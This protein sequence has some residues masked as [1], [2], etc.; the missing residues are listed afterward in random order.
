MSRY[1]E[2]VS[3]VV[4]VV[5]TDQN[6]PSILSMCS[7][8]TARTDGVVS[9]IPFDQT[10]VSYENQSDYVGWYWEES[11]GRVWQFVSC[12]YDNVV[13]RYYWKMKS[14]YAVPGEGITDGRLVNLWSG[15]LNGK[16]WLLGVCG[17]FLRRYDFDDMFSRKIAEL[18]PADGVDPFLF[19]FDGKVFVL[20][21][22]DFY[23]WDGTFDDITGNANFEEINTNN[24]Y[25]PLVSVSIPPGQGQSGTLLEP[26]NTLTT[27]QRCWI[28][29]DGVGNTFQLPCLDQNPLHTRITNRITGELVSTTQYTE[30]QG[31]VIKFNT[32]PEEGINT[33]E[34][35]FSPKGSS[36]IGIPI[37]KVTMAELYNGVNDSR[38]FYYGDSTNRIYYSDV[39]YNG[40]PRA[41]YVPATN[42][43]DIGESNTPVTCLVRNYSRLLAYKTDS[44][45]SIQY[46]TVTM[47][48]GT[49]SATFY[50]TPVN[51]V[52]GNEAKGQVRIVENTPVS[53]CQK[54]LYEWNNPNG[55]NS[56]VSVDERQAK[57]ISDNV[58]YTIKN[59]D[60]SKCYCFNDQVH[61]EY[62]IC[63]DKKAIVWNYAVDAWYYYT[64]FDVTSMVIWDGEL[65][66]GDSLGRLNHISNDYRTDN[67]V[68]FKCYWESGAE[69]FSKEFMRKY[70]SAL[71]IVVKPELRSEI[72]VTVET[73]RKSNNAIKSVTSSLFTFANADFRKWSFNTNRKPKTNRLKIKAKKFSYYKLILSVEGT[74][75]TA[76]VIA[77]DM[78]VRY[79]GYAK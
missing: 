9:V 57:R 41:D 46:G 1:E 75:T 32:V 73:D 34:I 42:F 48:D 33:Y 66:A 78:K 71:W 40:T 11:Y 18:K 12:D 24:A 25:I 10:S 5:R 45:Y 3:D 6:I 61:Q 39:D 2:K 47:P 16:E 63:Y 4:E 38:V 17:G 20:T 23:F 56:A 27:Y 44:V 31:G 19:G 60:F 8:V 7:S 77:A 30:H 26:V 14:V 37:Y 54:N 69:P 79:T 58:Y 65:Y 22:K 59:F 67:G 49:Q 51:K 15:N 53:L 21:G 36:T 76:T 64:D 70:S 55:Y 74:N 72:F 62:Y 28:S 29:P 52:I 50:A 68:E 43:I 13:K 35:R